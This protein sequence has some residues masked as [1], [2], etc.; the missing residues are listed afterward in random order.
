MARLA[1]IRDVASKVAGQP[2]A[3]VYFNPQNVAAVEPIF[4]GTKIRLNDGQEYK[5]TLSVADVVAL[6]QQAM[7]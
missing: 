4:N 5:T 7:L 3:T 1:E 6:I 2:S